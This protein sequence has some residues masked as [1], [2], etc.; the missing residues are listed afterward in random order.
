MKACVAELVRAQSSVLADMDVE[1]GPMKWF[2]DL[3][4]NYAQEADQRNRLKKYVDEHPEETTIDK[5]KRYMS[6][7]P[8]AEKVLKDL[9]EILPVSK[10]PLI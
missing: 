1:A 8:E 3:V 4:E 7:H 9:S 10:S 6:K 2:L 5:L